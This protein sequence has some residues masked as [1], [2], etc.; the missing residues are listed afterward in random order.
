MEEVK[1]DGVKKVEGGRYS[2]V[3]IW[4]KFSYMMMFKWN[5]LKSGIY[6]YG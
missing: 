5:F 2:D 1:E 6:I 4:L 3:F